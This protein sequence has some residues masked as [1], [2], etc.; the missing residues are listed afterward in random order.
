MTISNPLL[1]SVIAV[2]YNHERYLEETLDSIIAQHC[3][4]MQLIIIDDCSRDNSVAKIKNWIYRTKID[5]MFINRFNCI[6][7]Y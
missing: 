6:N 5:C 2:C 3:P 4:E 7:L 1:V